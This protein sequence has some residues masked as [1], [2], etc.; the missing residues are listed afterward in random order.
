MTEY[1]IVLVRDVLGNIVFV[2]RRKKDW[3]EGLLNLPGGHIEEWEYG[4]DAAVREFQEEVG[5]NIEV[6]QFGGFGAE[7][8]VI[9]VKE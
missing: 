2:R 9:V 4:E 1:V 6:E 8:I 7:S 5:W 3:Q